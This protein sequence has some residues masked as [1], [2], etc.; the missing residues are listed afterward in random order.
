MREPFGDKMKC[1]YWVLFGLFAHRDQVSIRMAAL[2]GLH[3]FNKLLK[4]VHSLH[5]PPGEA[6]CLRIG[7][8]LI[9]VLK[10]HNAHHR[11]S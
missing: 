9:E 3:V 7:P 4:S 5:T 2:R 10:V 11:T 1:L 6:I 8:R